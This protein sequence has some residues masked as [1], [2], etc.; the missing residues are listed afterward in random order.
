MKR[1]HDSPSVSGTNRKWYSAVMANC[2][3]D[4]ST[5]S[6]SIISAEILGSQ[7]EP[8]QLVVERLLR[9]AER[10]A[11]SRCVAAVTPQHFLDQRPFELHNLIRQ[12]SARRLD[13]FQ[14]PEPR[15]KE[16]EHEAIGNIVQ[17]THVA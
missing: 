2:S 13:A 15:T 5:R 16:T 12:R 4:T 7:I 10:F 6:G 17:F 11:C 3:R 9:Q 8:V 14:Q 1:I